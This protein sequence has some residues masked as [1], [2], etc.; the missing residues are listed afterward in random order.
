[1]LDMLDV[2]VILILLSNP[3]TPLHKSQNINNS[4]PI[5]A[6]VVIIAS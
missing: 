5:A 2:D 4:S 6:T 3:L 1:M